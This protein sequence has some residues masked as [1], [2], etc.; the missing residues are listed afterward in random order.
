MCCLFHLVPFVSWGI[1]SKCDKKMAQYRGWYIVFS[2]VCPGTCCK[3]AL[4]YWDRKKIAGNDKAKKN[5][6]KRQ[7]NGWKTHSPIRMETLISGYFVTKSNSTSYNSLPSL[8]QITCTI[9]LCRIIYAI[10][11]YILWWN[12]DIL[13]LVDVDICKC[14]WESHD[15]WWVNL[16]CHGVAGLAVISLKGFW[17]NKITL[18]RK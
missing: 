5:K 8:S 12:F 11:L 6:G 16:Q 7:N 9:L 15:P 13:V 3:L 14:H 2:Q 4:F 10:K 17:V 18:N 1:S